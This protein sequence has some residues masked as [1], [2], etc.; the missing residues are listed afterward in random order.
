MICRSVEFAKNHQPQHTANQSHYVVIIN[1][2]RLSLL[3]CCPS[4]RMFA[5]LSQLKDK[6]EGYVDQAQEKG[7]AL[8]VDKLHPKVH[9]VIDTRVD[10][11]RDS[12][13]EVRRRFECVTRS[14]WYNVPGDPPCRR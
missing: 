4:R 10:A 3:C 12:T 9:S 2:Y 1:T 13:L 11:F 6:V 14:G 5:K 7:V 8:L